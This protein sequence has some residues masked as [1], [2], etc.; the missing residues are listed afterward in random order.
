MRAGK[1]DTAGRGRGVEGGEGRV[2]VI[3]EEGGEGVELLGAVESDEGD[4]RAGVRD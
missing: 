2:D 3:E 1:Y 4:T